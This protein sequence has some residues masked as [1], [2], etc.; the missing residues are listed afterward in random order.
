MSTDPDTFPSNPKKSA[1]D[2]ARDFAT[3]AGNFVDTFVH[4]VVPDETAI[5]PAERDQRRREVCAAAWASFVATFDS[6]ALTDR[7]KARIVP[8]V[9]QDL[10][11]TWMKHCAGDPAHLDDITERSTHYLRH[12][13]RASQLATAMAIVKDLLG[14]IELEGTRAGFARRAASMI[15][16]RMLVDLG[17]LNDL[18]AKFTID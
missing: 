8:L 18:K 3:S 5:D 1:E 12:H 4:L 11:M 15:A 6:S 17:R 7:E 14:A 13:D 16:H 2:V 9:R 10:L